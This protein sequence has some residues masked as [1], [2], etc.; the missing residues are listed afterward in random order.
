M[1]ESLDITAD[2]TE[3]LLEWRGGKH[4]VDLG[5]FVRKLGLPP[6][7]TI[8]NKMG[9]IQILKYVDTAY[10]AAE[11]HIQLMRQIGNKEFVIFRDISFPSIS[12]RYRDSIPSGSEGIST[13]ELGLKLDKDT[14]SNPIFHSRF[15]RFDHKGSSYFAITALQRYTDERLSPVAKPFFSTEELQKIRLGISVKGL[16]PIK[17]KDPH[18]YGRYQ[19]ETAQI[20]RLEEALGISIPDIAFTICAALAKA[21]GDERL[22]LSSYQNQLWVKEHNRDSDHTEVPNFY[23]PTADFFGLSMATDLLGF[24]EIDGRNGGITF[25]N[26]SRASDNYQIK[27]IAQSA[28]VQLL[29]EIN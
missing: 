8:E 28:Y 20:N 24:Y 1:Q 9:I 21:C 4:G 6:S 19:K 23:D 10:D 14:I 18:R 11:K 25:L 12:F 17:V 22:L 5:H 3:L 29:H 15:M 7:E 2:P 26:H 16:D 13:I 27:A